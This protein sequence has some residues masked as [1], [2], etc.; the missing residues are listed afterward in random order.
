ML[1][2]RPDLVKMER[3]VKEIDPALPG[4]RGADRVRKFALGGKMLTKSGVNG[5]PTLATVEKGEQVLAAMAQD[6]ISFLEEFA[7]L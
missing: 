3:A 1:V 6:I 2:I 7:R 4:T 5:D